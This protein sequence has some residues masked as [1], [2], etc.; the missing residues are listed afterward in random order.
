MYSTFIFN[1][2]YNVLVYLVGVIPGGDVG[3]AVI[4]LTLLLRFVLLPL[5]QKAQKTQAGMR[6]LQPQLDAL[7]KQHSANPQIHM[8]E[9]QK[10]Y[11]EAGVSPFSSILLLLIQLPVL[12]G[13]YQ[14][15]N[16]GHLAQVDTSLLYSFVHVPAVVG[17]HF[18]GFIDMYSKSIF[19]ALA[20]GSTQ[21]LFARVMPVPPPS[22][23][24]SFA[25]DL[26]ASMQ[27]QMKYVFPAMIIV[28]AYTTSAAIALY[29]ITSNLA[30]IAQEVYNKR[31]GT[32]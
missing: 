29:L 22:T 10:L 25:N 7:K 13:L 28:V 4:I 15:F 27:M 26:A 3:I 9:M 30:S 32:R 16:Y 31:H 2:L 24:K 20:A 11:K 14:V 23:E 12:I 5:S 1:P 18:L 21:Y 19:L 17:S 6:I 8:K